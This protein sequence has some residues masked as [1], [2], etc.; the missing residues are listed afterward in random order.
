[1]KAIHDGEARCFLHLVGKLIVLDVDR[2]NLESR[3]NNQD[4]DDGEKD[5]LELA[6]SPF[7][8]AGRR[9][10]ACVNLVEQ[11]EFF[12]PAMPPAVYEFGDNWRHHSAVFL[13]ANILDG[14]CREAGS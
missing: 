10:A 13:H 12:L 7:G 9:Q 6:L 11:H 4:Q 5:G 2:H 8:A 14:G 3:V 1:L